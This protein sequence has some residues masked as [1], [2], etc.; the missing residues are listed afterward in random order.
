M[1]LRYS[2]QA[3]EDLEQIL[4]FIAKDSQVRA[5]SFIER[6]KMKIELLRDFPGLGVSC[7]SKG[8]T[9]DCRVLI[10]GSYLI[11]ILFLKRIFLF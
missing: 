11:F 7:R 8:I 2:E 9:E 5:V 3:L 6:I 10:F 1:E 4:S